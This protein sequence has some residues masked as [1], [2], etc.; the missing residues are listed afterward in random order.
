MSLHNLFKKMKNI[1]AVNGLAIILRLTSRCNNYLA[2]ARVAEA[3]GLTALLR[4]PT[5][6]YSGFCRSPQFETR[7]KGPDV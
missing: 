7:Q 1:R 6:V 3:D 5:R 4:K 2:G